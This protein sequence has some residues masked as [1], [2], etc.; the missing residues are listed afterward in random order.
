ML[1]RTSQPRA[2]LQAVATAVVRA[3]APAREQ[4]H[5][6]VTA[7]LIESRGPL[8][9]TTIHRMLQEVKKIVPEPSVP[10]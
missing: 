7:P 1:A 3:G 6:I 2:Q 10:R 4:R 8:D 5:G 9:A